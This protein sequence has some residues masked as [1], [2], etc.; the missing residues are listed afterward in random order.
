MK[1]ESHLLRSIQKKLGWRLVGGI[2]NS[3]RQYSNEF[4]DLSFS[5]T[6]ISEF[7]KFGVPV[8]NSK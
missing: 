1:A 8:V 6:P 2:L 3:T 7:L 5:F 4:G